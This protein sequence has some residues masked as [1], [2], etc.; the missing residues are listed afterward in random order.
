MKE[1]QLKD[2]EARVRKEIERKQ[3]QEQ[4][5]LLESVFPSIVNKYL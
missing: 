5:K 3:E 2:E 4:I 1:Q